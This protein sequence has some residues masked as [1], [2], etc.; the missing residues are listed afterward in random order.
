MAV[1]DY[2]NTTYTI[3]VLRT[4][5]AM[6]VSLT[7]SFDATKYPVLK[8]STFTERRRLEYQRNH[9]TWYAPD[10][11][12][13]SASLRVDMTALVLAPLTNHRG[14]NMA[15]VAASCNCGVEKPGGKSSR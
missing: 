1:G 11:D 14:L 4:T 7:S 10:I 13:S 8:G 15:S 12:L 2:A 9:R 3:H 5:E 6:N